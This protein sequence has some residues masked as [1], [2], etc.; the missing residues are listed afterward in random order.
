MRAVVTTE[1]NIDYGF[2]HN[3]RNE[4]IFRMRRGLL[5]NVFSEPFYV[6][7]GEEIT[8]GWVIGIK[9]SLFRRDEYKV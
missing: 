6:L 7:L 4:A 2:G 8:S 9:D 5:L 1:P 3:P